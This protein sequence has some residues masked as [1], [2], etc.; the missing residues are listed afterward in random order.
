MKLP[1]PVQV[2]EVLVDQ[3]R[4]ALADPELFEIPVALTPA[5]PVGWTLAFSAEWTARMH[6]MWRMA[7]VVYDRPDGETMIRAPARVVVTCLPE[8]MDLYH[9]PR[10]RECAEAANQML[11]QA[12]VKAHT[13]EIAASDRLKA[14]KAALRRGVR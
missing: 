7:Q 6:P 11:R 3:I 13:Q 9:M 1:E 10:L 2:G 5:V 8:E 4:V 12:A 14:A